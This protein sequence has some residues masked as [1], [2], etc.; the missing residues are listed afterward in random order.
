MTGSRRFIVFSIVFLGAI[1]FR[2]IPALANGL[3]PVISISSG[4]ANP[5]TIGLYVGGALFLV[6]MVIEAAVFVKYFSFTWIKALFAAFL[7]NIFSSVG[8]FYLSGLIVDP[9]NFGIGYF[10]LVMILLLIMLGRH[11]PVWFGIRILYTLFIGYIAAA[12]TRDLNEGFP[13]WQMW[14]A[15]FSPMLVAFGITLL[16]EGIIVKGFIK[17]DNKWQGLFRANL[18]SYFFLAIFVVLIGSNPIQQRIRSSTLG[19]Y[20]NRFNGSN[21][22]EIIESLH[23]QRASNL[24][25]LGLI[26][27]DSPLRPYNAAFE[28]NLMQYIGCPRWTYDQKN[29]WFIQLITD[30]TSDVGWLTTS[31]KSELAWIKVNNA[32]FTS[33]MNA[34][35]PDDNDAYDEVIAEWE[36]WYESGKNYNRFLTQLPWNKGKT[37]PFGNPSD[38][39][40]PHRG[41]YR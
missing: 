27:Y 25:H 12:A 6:V 41:R 14:L 13:H 17:A 31:A 24:Y 33:A 35:D 19:G 10:W 32:Y 4:S 40:K 11:V 8:G 15:L 21:E 30:D 29:Q 7:L 3:L 5:F 9:F 18:Y 36:E 38:Y 37:M 20:V 34:R 16:V 23:D 2:D 28:I 22:R 26:K 1:I 39:K